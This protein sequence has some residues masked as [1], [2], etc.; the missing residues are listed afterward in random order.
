M[1]K[2]GKT[3]SFAGRA[4]IKE[5]RIIPSSPISEA[6]GSRK[7]AIGKRRSN[8]FKIKI[9]QP[10]GA[11]TAIAR[12]STAKVLSKSERIKTGIIRGR[13][14]GG[15]S[16]KKP[17]LSPRRRVFDSKKD[18]KR[19]T[20]VENDST[21]TMQ[22]AVVRLLPKE[23]KSTITAISAPKRPLQG[24]SEFVRIAMSLSRLEGMIA[25]PVMPTQLQPK[26]M[27]MVSACLP[28]LPHFLKALSR[29]NATRGRK[30]KSSSRVKSG[31]NIAMGG[32]ITAITV[33][34]VEY[35]P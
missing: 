24:V 21:P 16:R 19:E 18:D 33:V 10:M 7:A 35:M 12:K 25:L 3:I 17:T 27:H 32:S 22:R 5:R 1:S 15:I 23:K 30:P 4:R 29:L 11:A 2:I 9:T 6:K 26:P 8:R 28:Q 13:R 31:K 20:R 34:V 14:K